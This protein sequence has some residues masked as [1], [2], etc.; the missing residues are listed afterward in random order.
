MILLGAAL[1]LSACG[2]SARHPVVI[3][4]RPVRIAPPSPTALRFST[5]ANRRF[6]RDDVRRLLGILELPRGARVVARMPRSAP[7]SARNDLLGTRFLPGIATTHR[8]WVVRD[9]PGRVLRFV[10]T[11]A[12]PRPRPYARFRGR[13]YGVRFRASGSYQFPPVPGRSWDRWLTADVVPLSDGGTAVIAQAGD[14]WVHQPRRTLL[15]RAVRRIDVLS[16]IGNGAPNVLVYVRRRYDVGSIISLVNGL[17][18]ADAE[19]I[20]CAWML[21]GGP[22]VTLRFRAANGKRLARATVADTRGSG[23]SGP[24]D[25][26]QLSVRGRSATPLIGSDLLLRLERL[27]QIDLSPASPREVSNCL[28][29]RHG[30]RVGRVHGQPPELIVRRD[31]KRW[32]ITFHLTGRLTVDRHAPRG[33]ERCVSARPRYVI[34]G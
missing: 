5:A 31:G 29:R 18:L 8:I 1:L 26:L 20:S 28:L 12:H 21:S 27:L 4:P 25:P 15:P 9:P 11:H 3:G 34:F 33:L 17:G 13:N 23:R 19:R 2:S 10:Q 6:A 30:W 7:P 22:T 16:R 14:A 24:C 32:T